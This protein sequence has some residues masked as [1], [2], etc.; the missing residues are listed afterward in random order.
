MLEGAYVGCSIAVNG[1]CLT[2][3][4]FDSECFKVGLAP[5][6]LR[7][8]NLGSLKAGSRVNLESA[9][10]VNGTYEL[11]FGSFWYPIYQL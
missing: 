2:A 11:V 7:R 1:V 9:L 3:L 10:A 6:T 4:S 8:S 5:E